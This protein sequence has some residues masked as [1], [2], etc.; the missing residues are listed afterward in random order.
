VP[1]RSAPRAEAAEPPA[2][3]AP[4]PLL[5]RLGERVRSRRQD[6][7]LTLRELSRAASVSERFLVMV[8]SGHA[9]VSVARL[10]DI[11]TAL[12]TSPAALLADEHASHAGAKRGALV[13][14]LG[15]RGAGK[16]T[17]G[18]RAAQRLGVP[19]VELDALVAERAGMSLAAIFEMHGNA[20]Y[21]RLEREALDA[22][23]QSGDA[24]IVAT[25]GG[26]VTDHAT[27]AELRRVAVTIWLKARADDHWARVVAQ[28]D[29]RPMANRADAM[30]ELRALLG[31]R[32]ALYER[33][34]HIVDTSALG[35]ERA[36]SE[37]VKLARRAEAAPHQA[38][39]RAP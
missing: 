5:L 33:A 12:G 1:L 21:R 22:L 18:A 19:F 23:A 13:A 32:R 26:I 28:G 7:A 14:L 24:A 30:K 9:N 36:V 2:S 31:A 11:A 37:V 35:L 16:S 15:L 6:L 27:F 34:D 20:S 4:R 25:G 3:A 10:E 8:E 17:I 39:R 29:A 38:V